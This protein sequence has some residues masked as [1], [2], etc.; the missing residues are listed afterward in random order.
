MAIIDNKGRSHQF[1]GGK[2]PKVLNR[3][4]YH[5]LAEL[6]NVHYKTIIRWIDS[7]KLNPNDIKDIIRLYQQTAG[8]SHDSCHS[9][10][11]GGTTS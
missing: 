8:V 1:R 7:G 5:S 4:T 6:F 2:S 9:V 3:I 11:N 10:D